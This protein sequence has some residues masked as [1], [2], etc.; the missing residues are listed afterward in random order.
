[1]EKIRIDLES[2]TFLET[3]WRVLTEELAERDEGR[4]DW[5]TRSKEGVA[6]L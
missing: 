5:P 3:C 1:M 2:L 6:F 4:C